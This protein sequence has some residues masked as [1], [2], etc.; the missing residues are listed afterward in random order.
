METGIRWLRSSRRGSALLATMILIAVMAM[1]LLSMLA[2]GLSGNRSVSGQADDMRLTGAVESAGNLAAQYL[3]TTYLRA[4]GGAAGDIDSFR[5][6]LDGT[7]LLDSGP[8]GPPPAGSGM[9]IL[10]SV[11]LPTGAGG[12][13]ELDRARIQSLNVLRRD[14]GEATRL[15]VTAVADTNRGTPG[16]HPEARAVEL[17]YT[18]EP[19]PFPG[20]DYGILSKNINCVFCHTIVDSAR[21]AYDT[22]PAHYG[23]FD[24]VKVGSL[25]TLMLRVPARE[26]ISDSSADSLLAG[27]MY[28]RG[29][30]TD[31]HG[32][33]ISG[34][35]WLTNTAQSCEFDQ[36]GHLI[37]DATGG[38][39]PQHFDPAG[40]PPQPGANLYL[41]YP[42]AYAD[43]P[44]GLL[45]ATFPPPFPDDGGIDPVT[46][47]P[48]TRGAGNRRVDPGEFAAVAR[49]AH[50]AIQ[51]GIV[52]VSNPGAVISTQA[53]LDR[54]FAQGNATNLPSVTTGNVIL[55]GTPSNPIVINGTIAIDGD[56]VIQGWVKGTGA[57]MAS[58]N[59]YVPGDLRYLDGHTY[60]DGDLPGHPTGPLTFGVAQDGTQ[61]TLGLAAGGNLLLGDYLR[62]ESASHPLPGQFVDGSTSGGWNFSLSEIAIFNRTEWAHTQPLLPGMGE[63]PANPSTWTVQ[64]P[65]YIPGYMP[66]Y[67]QFGPG[68]PIPIFNL[69]DLHFDPAT[70]TWL[71][72]E[73]P[74]DWNPTEMTIVDPN[75]HT[76]PLLYDPTTGAPRA[77][78]LQSTPQ[79]GWLPDTLA[80]HAIETFTNARPAGDPARLDGL[81]YTNNAIFGLFGRDDRMM[82]KMVVNGSLVCADLG[83]LA[84]GNLAQ[85]GGDNPPG[86][87]YSVGLRLNYDE[88]TKGM[89]NVRN[90]N[91][92]TIHR[93]MWLPTATP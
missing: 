58:G 67:Y 12:V 25:E 69:A 31:Q 6:F 38:L 13:S 60:L 7:G 74:F 5:R 8:G 42:T 77:A 37:Q 68:D 27:T 47:Q 14:E 11:G 72:T 91:Q 28:V 19:A 40:D 33:P 61:N 2:S 76:N 70:G 57:I 79:G 32:V 21:R 9:D 30:A 87:P 16:R 55:S 10:Q 20:F 48:S 23:T 35:G 54:A 51:S 64:N 45:P 90:P 63:D 56:V 88:R 3:W 44:D 78:V 66:R 22:D 80:Q 81:Y 46:G 71:G 89:L 52:Y 84:P 85:G 39:I 65:G 86:S 41:H 36:A 92:V 49:D 83:L 18:V 17:A 4:N 34:P 24:K 29:S 43:Q 82:G 93:A 1:L 59:V 62:P 75:D 50:G 53:Q 26:R 15:Y 73:V